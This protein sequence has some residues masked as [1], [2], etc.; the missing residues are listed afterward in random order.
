MLP[1][2]ST[3][4]RLADPKPMPRLV[5][6]A[7]GIALGKGQTKPET[8]G[9]HLQP[10]ERVGFGEPFFKCLILCGGD[11]QRAPCVVLTVTR[12]RHDREDSA[13]RFPVRE[14]VPDEFGLACDTAMT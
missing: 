8:W 11:I 3:K 5:G 14:F 6:E 7:R 10:F 2:N 1:L 4:G 13:D 9:I 12:G